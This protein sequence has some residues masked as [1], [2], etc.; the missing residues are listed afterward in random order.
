MR[1]MKSSTNPMNSDR[2]E[3]K[4][5]PGA[6]LRRAASAAARRFFGPPPVADTPFCDK[7]QIIYT[8]NG[9]AVALWD[10]SGTAGGSE[11]RIDDPQM[12]YRC[13]D[14]LKLPD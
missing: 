4:R 10:R 8:Q 14:P 7:P 9:S 1:N 2:P 12:P 11:A 6:T 5:P 13:V 3:A